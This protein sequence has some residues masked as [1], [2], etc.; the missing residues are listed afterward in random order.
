MELD[1]NAPIDLELN[2]EWGEYG[3]RIWE[4]FEKAVEDGMW[5][6]EPPDHELISVGSYKGKPALITRNYHSSECEMRLWAGG[7]PSRSLEVCSNVFVYP[8]KYD[9]SE[10][11]I[12]EDWT[13]AF[14]KILKGDGEYDIYNEMVPEDF[15]WAVDEMTGLEEYDKEEM[16]LGK[17]IENEI[18]GL[19][20]IFDPKVREIIQQKLMDQDQ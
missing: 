1:A 10:N 7:P 11:V 4:N 5:L 15:L 12:F 2:A 9:L 16:E 20:K 19:D 17:F 8:I 6:G 3:D 14:D 18:G 13:F